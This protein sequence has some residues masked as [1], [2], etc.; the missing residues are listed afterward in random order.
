[1]PVTLAQIRARVQT[2]VVDVVDEITAEFDGWINWAIRVAQ[3]THNFRAM[4]AEQ[5]KDTT[6]NVRLL[7]TKFIDW[8]DRRLDPYYVTPEGSNIRLSWATEDQARERYGENTT[9][10]IGPPKDLVERIFYDGTSDLDQFL[11]YPFPDA[12]SRQVG[13]APAAGE[14]RILI[15]YYRYLPT[16]AADNASNY[17]TDNWDNYVVWLAAAQALFLNEFNE[18]ALVFSTKAG[19]DVSE[20]APILS[21]TRFQGELGRMIKTD[22]RGR[23]ANRLTLGVNRNA[24]RSGRFRMV[25]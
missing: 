23:V 1:M 10:D 3:E 9:Q 21:G 6:K 11:V 14:Y 13:P 7:G 16:L 17:F 2:H 22:Q 18:R 20:G 12:L 25:R 4:Q 8:K 19:Y 24:G 5:F 15:P